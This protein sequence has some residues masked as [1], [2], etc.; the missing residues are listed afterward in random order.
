M[1][2]QATFRQDDDLRF[3]QDDLRNRGNGLSKAWADLFSLLTTYQARLMVKENQLDISEKQ[4][5]SKRKQLAMLKD[6]VP[7]PSSYERLQ[8]QCEIKDQLLSKCETELL[9]A[10]QMLQSVQAE[11]SSQAE[12]LEKVTSEKLEKEDMILQYQN[13]IARLESDLQ[14]KEEESE[15]K[16]RLIQKLQAEN[17]SESSNMA[18]AN[19]GAARLKELFDMQTKTLDDERDA[20]K[21]TRRKLQIH[22]VS[23]PILCCY[24]RII[25][26]TTTTQM[27]KCY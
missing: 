5:Q 14:V 18:D 4:I 1:M 22:Q 20:H 7:L 12:H 13:R 11:L 17:L 10:T 2:E 19:T 15:I 6:G 24:M 16:D 21:E 3:L 9:N 8:D 25:V 27:T 26:L 23:F